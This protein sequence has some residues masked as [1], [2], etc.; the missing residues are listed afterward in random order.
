MTKSNR[1]GWL[2][3]I[4]K[5]ILD[6]FPGDSTHHPQASTNPQAK[7]STIPTQAPSTAAPTVRQ[8]APPDPPPER[9]EALSLISEAAPTKEA[10]TEKT[11][12]KAWKAFELAWQQAGL[13]SQYFLDSGDLISTLSVLDKTFEDELIEWLYQLCTKPEAL[14]NLAAIIE[15]GQVRP[16]DNVD[17]IR[18]FAYV[19]VV[20]FSRPSP[21]PARKPDQPQ[22]NRPHSS[23]E[24][25]AESR[26]QLGGDE[27]VNSA[28]APPTSGSHS[29]ADSIS[30]GRVANQAIEE[31]GLSMRTYN[32]LKRAG[33][34]TLLDLAEKNDDKLLD[35]KNFGARSV[36]EVRNA[37]DKLGLE[38]P[39]F[40]SEIAGQSQKTDADNTQQDTA[41]KKVS[42]GDLREL[43]LA[44]RTLTSLYRGNVFSLAEL[45]RCTES[46]LLS[47]PNLGP[48]ALD[49]IRCSLAERG[50]QLAVP[51]STSSTGEQGSAQASAEE[52]ESA[53]DRLREKAIEQ[54]TTS[55]LSPEQLSELC[56]R[57][58]GNPASAQLQELLI[59]LNAV[60]GF[61]SDNLI[62]LEESNAS[63]LQLSLNALQ[64]VLFGDS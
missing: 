51:T 62:P 25:Q 22:V 27:G 11:L 33:I 9:P 35:I 47:F 40:A 20:V 21:Q 38:L 59:R 64:E 8:T 31:L 43:G 36:G 44:A 53:W 60:I 6:V 30:A 46:D 19:S 23:P 41:T 32:S 29:S 49:E 16:T 42:P 26:Q 56:Q 1:R 63:D 58:A 14:T 50:L 28:A 15:R 52:L 2:D 54:H 57:T 7:P 4:S 24:P 37:L 13:S 10:P 48:T 61:L 39:F 5:W 45:I 55:F 34:H 17:A 3:K 12:I 18:A